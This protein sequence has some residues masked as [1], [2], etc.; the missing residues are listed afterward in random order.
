MAQITVPS[1]PRPQYE[2]SATPS[3]TSTDGSSELVTDIPQ[4]ACC[5]TRRSPESDRW[6]R[7]FRPDRRLRSRKLLELGGSAREPASSWPGSDVFERGGQTC[8]AALLGE[9]G[10]SRAVNLH[11]AA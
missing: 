5:L 3:T 6:T 7:V 8:L 1:F 11:E 2:V 9:Y 10:V 4:V